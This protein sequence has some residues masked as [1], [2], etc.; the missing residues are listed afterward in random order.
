LQVWDY[1]KQNDLTVVT[2]DMDFYELGFAAV[3]AIE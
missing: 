3:Y 2:K 1:A